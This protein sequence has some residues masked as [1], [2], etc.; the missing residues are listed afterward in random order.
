METNSL[1]WIGLAKVK[2]LNNSNIFNGVDF[3]YTNVIGISKSKTAFRISVRNKLN[4]MDLELLRLQEI[5][6]LADR[7][8]KFEV[9]KDI[10]TIAKKLSELNDVDFSTFHTY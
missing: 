10:L 3:A 6:S 7:L 9:S 2:V 4:L 8:K 5:E 1:K